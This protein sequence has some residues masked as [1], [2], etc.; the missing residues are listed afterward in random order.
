M[1]LIRPESSTNNT[2]NGHHQSTRFMIEYYGK[3]GVSFVLNKNKN[4]SFFQTD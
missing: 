4:P 2:S 1:G 3:S